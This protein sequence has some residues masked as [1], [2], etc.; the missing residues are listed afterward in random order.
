VRQR[1]DFAVFAGADWPE[2]VMNLEIHDRFHAK[3]G[4]STSRWVLTA[5]G[6]RLAVYLKRHYDLPAWRAWL[7]ALIPKAGC[8]PA[9]KEWDHLQ[10]ARQA[11]IPVPHSVAAAEFIGPRGRFQSMLAVEELAGM[12]PLHEAIPAAAR[13]LDARKF[14]SWKRGL[15]DE[16]ARLT[17]LLHEPRRFHKDLYLCHF[18]IP[19]E[20]VHITPP[21]RGAVHLIDLHRLRH[22]PWT[23]RIFQVKDLGQLL[24]SSDVL[25]VDARDRL[26]F[27][28]KYL[29]E[30]RGSEK[31]LRRW[32]VAKWRRYHQHNRKNLARPTAA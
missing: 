21:W 17:R 32:V 25:G 18:F 14:A 11:G 4:R 3:Q 15:I 10:W 5:G 7:A 28:R 24:Y 9:F 2:R 20:F 31:W 26:R 8:S 16:L 19:S 22:H 12:A 29:G 30:K 1:A 27:W 6:K 13:A 23:W